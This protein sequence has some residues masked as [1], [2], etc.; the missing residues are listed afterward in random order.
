MKFIK[1]FPNNKQLCDGINVVFLVVTMGNLKKIE[2]SSM[3]KKEKLQAYDRMLK[4][5]ELHHVIDNCALSKNEL[6]KRLTLACKTKN[7]KKIQSVFRWW[8]LRVKLKK[9]IKNK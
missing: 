1:E 4:Y 2:A 7:P 6:T 5:T 9:I 3:T 8:N